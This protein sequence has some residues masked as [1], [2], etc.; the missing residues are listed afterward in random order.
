[1]DKLTLV[2]IV[3][4]GFDLLIVGGGGWAIYSARAQ[5]RKLDAGT[6]KEL[7]GAK[8]DLA[9]ARHTDVETS[10]EWLEQL[11]SSVAEW[12][13]VMGFYAE[14]EKGKARAEIRVQEVEADN[15]QLRAAN[16]MLAKADTV[17]QEQ[18]TELRGKLKDAGVI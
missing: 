15:R 13:K 3:R 12:Q 14:C 6:T 8:K 16:E 1:M 5:R 4:W 11:K 18:V 10:G 7:A 17:W 9:D 2:D